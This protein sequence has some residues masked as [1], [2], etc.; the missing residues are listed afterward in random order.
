MI[1]SASAEQ[2]STYKYKPVSKTPLN[3]V[4]LILDFLSIYA[5]LCSDNKVFM[6]FKTTNNEKLTIL[7]GM[8]FVVNTS[9][10]AQSFFSVTT[11]SVSNVAANSATF[12]L[13]GLSFTD[14]VRTGWMFGFGSFIQPVGFVNSPM[15]LPPV[16]RSFNVAG[17][18]TGI[19]YTVQAIMVK[20]HRRFV[21][22]HSKCR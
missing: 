4:F 2:N 3:R 22:R 15:M 16:S 21:Y 18:F 1:I 13:T 7:F 19:P 9:V 5:I 17:L 10:F 8:L 14:S 6:S 11:D 12:H 20:R